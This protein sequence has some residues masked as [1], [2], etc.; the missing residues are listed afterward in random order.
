M[1]NKHTPGPWKIN[2]PDWDYEWECYHDPDAGDYEGYA[3]IDGEGWSQLA[4]VSVM[5]NGDEDEA[6]KANA[7]LIAAAPDLLLAC[8]AALLKFKHSPLDK[9]SEAADM[10]RNAIA[11]ATAKE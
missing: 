6:G 8:K 1:E 7:R 11:K 5:V 9:I 3:S 4:K 2:W 10:L